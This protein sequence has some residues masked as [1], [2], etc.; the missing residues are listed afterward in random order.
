MKH[1]Y[2]KI[3]QEKEN[4]NKL[5]S[6]II[7][8]SLK[9]QVQVNPPDSTELF[10]PLLS[11]FRRLILVFLHYHEAANTIC[12]RLGEPAKCTAA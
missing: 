5:S 9:T 11:Y 6:R 12:M 10:S 8:G 4:P 1:G 3:P 7:R 2:S